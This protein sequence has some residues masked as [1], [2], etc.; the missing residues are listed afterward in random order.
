LS[1]RALAVTNAPPPAN[2]NQSWA[3]PQILV[4][5]EYVAVVANCGKSSIQQKQED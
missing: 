4:N 2:V 5:R 1:R 3:L